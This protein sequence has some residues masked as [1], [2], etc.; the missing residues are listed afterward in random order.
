M[1][2]RNELST[3]QSCAHDS[4]GSGTKNVSVH[5]TNRNTIFNSPDSALV[6]QH[7]HF[8]EE[9]SRHQDKVTHYHLS[10]EKYSQ[11]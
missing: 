10:A 2:Q 6:R 9:K 1:Y 7:Q 3:I 11:R 5:Y 8:R 4:V